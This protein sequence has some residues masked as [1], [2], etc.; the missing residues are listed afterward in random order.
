VSALEQPPDLHA[1]DPR[2]ERILEYLEHGWHVLRAYGLAES[3][4]P[5]RPVCLCKEGAACPNPGKHP[6]GR[7]KEP[8]GSA[9]I[10]GPEELLSKLPPGARW[11]VALTFRTGGLEDVAALDVDTDAARV[12]LLEEYGLDVLEARCLQRTSNGWHALYRVPAERRGELPEES[13]LKPGASVFAVPN[14]DLRYGGSVI[15]TAPSVHAS[16]TEYRWESLGEPEDAP[17]GF[18]KLMQTRGR[19][20]EAE[21]PPAPPLAPSPQP[22]PSRKAQPERIEEKRYRRAVEEACRA[23]AGASR[24]R[25]NDAT[26]RHAYGLGRSLCL[27]P[28]SYQLEAVGELQRAAE[29]HTP[30]GDP[31]HANR[32]E[33]VELSFAEGVRK[34][35][36][37]PRSNERGAPIPYPGSEAR[38][39]SSSGTDTPTASDSTEPGAEDETDTAKPDQSERV[40]FRR[41]SELG[42][43]EPVEWLEGGIAFGRIPRGELSIVFGNPGVGKGSIC[44]QVVAQVTQAGRDVIV[45]TPEDDPTRVLLPRLMAAGAVLER[46]HLADLTYGEE[47]G[48][49]VKVAPHARRLLEQVEATSAALLYLDP[50][51]EHLAGDVKSQRDT[52]NELRELLAGCREA[53]CAILAVDHS[54]RMTSSSAYARAGG[55]GAKYQVARSVMVAGKLETAEGD[56]PSDAIRSSEVLLIH[57]K[58]N[59]SGLANGLRFRLEG[60]NLEGSGNVE[61]RTSRA[62]LIGETNLTAEDMLSE[63][64]QEQSQTVSECAEWLAGYLEEHGGGMVQDET[65]KAARAVSEDWSKDV[66]KLAIRK[67]GGKN[68]P[69]GQGGARWGYKL[70]GYV[71]LGEDRPT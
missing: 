35:L 5:A 59:L 17:A 52:R 22:S 42:A 58:S 18:W 3:S 14:V 30:A 24:G 4:T 49:P 55:S 53:R 39:F 19:K 8:A 16:G 2:Y 27:W 44:M 62:E 38:P 46:I 34:G 65:R 31:D 64:A 66:L 43:P 63:K 57:A 61:I 67:L 15:I 50:F 56:Q 11:N 32:L 47:D 51:E 45:S 37:D 21:R 26:M 25:R 48:G 33:V 71:P 60:V 13:A 41:L 6:R 7:W 54:N 23:V 70:P 68:G 12:R 9:Y 10:R 40:R 20:A 69:M 1:L 28:E 29:T 36:G